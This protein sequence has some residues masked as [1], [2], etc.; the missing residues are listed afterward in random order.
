MS[1][2]PPSKKRPTWYAATTV[3]PNANVSGSTSV[4]CW[5]DVFVN[6]SALTRVSV[7]L[8]APAVAS[9]ATTTIPIAAPAPIRR[10]SV[11]PAVYQGAGA[12]ATLCVFPAVRL[13]TS[14]ELPGL[15]SN[16]QP[17]G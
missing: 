17:S 7:T 14:L 6:G 10:P 12:I 2:P 16:Q 5:L 8:A 4:A 11:T 13:G 3:E 15:D 9:T 1:A